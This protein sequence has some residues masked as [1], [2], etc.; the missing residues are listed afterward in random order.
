[1]RVILRALNPA[2]RRIFAPHIAA[3]RDANEALG[4]CARAFEPR[5]TDPTVR[6][7]ADALCYYVEEPDAKPEVAP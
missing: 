4:L 3:L 1:M 6:F 5:M 7:D 2:E